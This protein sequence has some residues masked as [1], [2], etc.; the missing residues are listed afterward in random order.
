M[1]ITCS[2]SKHFYSPLPPTPLRTTDRGGTTDR[3]SGGRFREIPLGTTD[4][5]F[6]WFSLSALAMEIPRQKSVV[7]SHDKN[8]DFCRGTRQFA[9]HD[10]D[11]KLVVGFKG[12]V[13]GSS[14]QCRVREREALR[15]AA[16]GPRESLI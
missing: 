16:A 14:Q 1:F 13:V 3:E 6:T 12:F 15:G 9:P 2:F 5:D 8:P 7:G 11:F 4:R 10:K